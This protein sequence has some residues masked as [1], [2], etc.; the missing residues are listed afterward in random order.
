MTDD[1][2]EIIKRGWVN[3]SNVFPE[4]RELA[5]DSDWKRREDAT[6]ALVEIC[7]KKKKRSFR[8]C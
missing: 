7:R 8:K 1:V 5:I 3:P 2:R 4:I 6:T